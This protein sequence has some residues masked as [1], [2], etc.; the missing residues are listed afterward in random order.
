MF[1]EVRVALEKYVLDKDD[2]FRTHILKIQ[3]KLTAEDQVKSLQVTTRK[4]KQ[5]ER[6][7][8]KSKKNKTG[9]TI[10][11]SSGQTRRPLPP[12][13]RQRRGMRNEHN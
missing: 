6:K 13:T 1:K 5:Q 2:A 4:R 7:E 12:P 11:C 8:A 3:Q 9:S 10:S